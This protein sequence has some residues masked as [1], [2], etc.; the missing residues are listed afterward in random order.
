MFSFQFSRHKSQLHSQLVWS[1]GLN[2]KKRRRGRHLSCMQFIRT[3]TF[4]CFYQLRQARHVNNWSNTATDPSRKPSYSRT[5][6]SDFCRARI[7]PYTCPLLSRRL[8][9]KKRQRHKSASLALSTAPSGTRPVHASS[10]CIQ[11]SAWCRTRCQGLPIVRITTTRTISWAIHVFV[12]Y[13]A[14]TSSPAGRST[15]T[16]AERESVCC[17]TI[18]ETSIYTFYIHSHSWP[19]SCGLTIL[20]TCVLLIVFLRFFYFSLLHRMCIS[21]LSCPVRWHCIA[22]SACCITM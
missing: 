2:A 18:C 10:V 8:T 5:C 9:S 20:G 7:H 4:W 15:P 6:S 14:Y 21:C 3:H 22:Y 13:V 12:L 11:S 17:R 1:P 19:T 16:P